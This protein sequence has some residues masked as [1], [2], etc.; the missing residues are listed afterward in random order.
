[1]SKRL[2]ETQR[3]ARILEIVARI[4]SQP[5]VWTRAK[6][7][8]SFEVSERQITKDLDIVR[9]GLRLELD[10]EH[11]GG[12]YF[13]SLPRLPALSYSLS[14]A[15]AIFLSAQA[16]RRLAGIPQEDLSAAI[17]RLTSIMPA[18]LVP[19]LTSG[20]LLPAS[21]LR[22]P[23][24]ER[25]L[26]QLDQAIAARRRLQVQYVPAYRPSEVTKREID[27]YVVLPT[28]SSWHVVGWCHLRN[29]VRI[30][31][32]DRI[33]SMRETGATF[34]PDPEFDVDEFLQAG[35]GITRVPD[36]DPVQVEIL[37]EGPAARWVSEELW[38]P[39]QSFDWRQ[40]GRLL[41]RVRVPITEE[42]GRWVLRYGPL[43]EV[44]RPAAL[45]EWIAE[46]AEAMARVNRAPLAEG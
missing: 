6:L 1:M 41:Y 39:S 12:Y 33:K 21:P 35:W 23:H 17:G 20:T 40:D 16:G 13:R 25:M 5:R 10:R 22:D 27:P 18:E 15:L 32:I 26:A 38:H 7:A 3:A 29:D 14:E 28:G 31:K 44:L 11:G 19:L 34:E 45:R 8:S 46:Q 36:Q 2:P 37:F 4:S 30:F 43:A 24:R 9:H 42:F